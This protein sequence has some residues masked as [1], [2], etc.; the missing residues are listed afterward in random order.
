MVSA[1]RLVSMGT[2]TVVIGLT[3]RASSNFDPPADYLNLKPL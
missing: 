2:V 3:V 1:N